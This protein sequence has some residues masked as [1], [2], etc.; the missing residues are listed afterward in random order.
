MKS[1]VHILDEISV[2]GMFYKTIGYS[3][4]LVCINYISLSESSDNKIGGISVKNFD[5]NFTREQ[6]NLIHFPDIS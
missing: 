5:L 4:I 3:C 1:D 6:T 2:G